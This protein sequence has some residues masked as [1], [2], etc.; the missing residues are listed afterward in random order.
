M[1]TVPIRPLAWEPPYAV[2]V[3]QE[4][5]KRQKKLKKK[6]KSE[7]SKPAWRLSVCVDRTCLRTGLTVGSGQPACHFTR[8]IWSLSSGDFDFSQDHRQTFSTRPRIVNILGFV[9]QMVFVATIL[10][11][12]RTRVAIDNL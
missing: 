6:L 9:D 1:A 10:I 8:G 5:T 12:G 2:G 7:G 4:N 3:A 11:C